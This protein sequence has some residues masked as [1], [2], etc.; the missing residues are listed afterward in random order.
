MNEENLNKYIGNRIKEYRKKL[1]I[2][3]ED[4]GNKLG[5]KNNTVSAYER[6]TISPDSDTLFAIASALGVSVDDFFPKNNNNNTNYLDQFKNFSTANLELKDM[7]FFQELVEKTLSLEGEEREKF[8][9]SIRFT[10]E[11]YNRMNKN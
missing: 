2:T 4:L 6:G 10:V 3:Q 9:E 8:L 11:Y 7:I 5:V 1:G